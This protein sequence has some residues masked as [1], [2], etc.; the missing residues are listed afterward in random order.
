MPMQ[1]TCEC[2]NVVSIHELWPDA[3]L[4][5]IQCGRVI[6]MPERPISTAVVAVAVQPA[7]DE[8]GVEPRE[9]RSTFVT[10][11]AWV[12]IVLSGFGTFMTCA[13]NVFLWAMFSNAEF[14]ADVAG[15]GAGWI[16]TF[17]PLWFGF[18]FCMN[19]AT[20]VSSIGLLQRREWGR[21]LFMG[22]LGF[23]AAWC[24]IGVIGHLGFSVTMLIGNADAPPDVIVMMG[25][26]TIISAVFASA[27]AVLL[28]WVLRRL[29]REEI[30]S[31]FRSRGK[32]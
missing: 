3:T 29:M 4:K 15:S 22:I 9:L 20:L 6:P 26:M 13:Q 21:K 17:M 8:G 7:A 19:V 31:E 12:F 28:I 1:V 14:R 11:V 24:I 2:G 10:V 32:T 23:G 5:C 25:F 16:L 27:I 30:R 18:A